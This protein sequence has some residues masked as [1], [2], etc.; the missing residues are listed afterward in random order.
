MS[1]RR[2]KYFTLTEFE[3]RCGCGANK[4]DVSLVDRLDQL[5]GECDFPIVVT[6]GYRCPNHNEAVSTTGRDGPHTTGKATDVAV[7]GAQA[8]IMLRHALS[9]KYQFFGVGLNQRGEYNKRFIHL[10]TL[11]SPDHTPRPHVWTY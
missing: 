11:R 8:R 9:S 2:W 1:E 6:S 7:S 4:I 10:D 5:R 3:C